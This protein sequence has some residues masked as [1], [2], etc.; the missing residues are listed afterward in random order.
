MDNVIGHGVAG[1]AIAATLLGMLPTALGIC[2]SILG[3]IWF[4][5]SIYETKTFQAYLQRRRD[6]KVA[7]LKAKLLLLEPK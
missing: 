1:S 3:I 5:V 7:K 6:R 4:I 2:G